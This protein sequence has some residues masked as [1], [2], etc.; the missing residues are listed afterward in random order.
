MIISCSLLDQLL[1]RN[2]WSVNNFT[3]FMLHFDIISFNQSLLF[4]LFQ[5]CFIFKVLTFSFLLL[6]FC[7]VFFRDAG[8]KVV[9]ITLFSICLSSA[10]EHDNQNSYSK[11]K[12]CNGPPS[13]N[14]GIGYSKLKHGPSH[15]SIKKV[16]NTQHEDDQDYIAKRVLVDFGVVVL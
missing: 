13:E 4:G 7:S 9:C 3:I 2:R 15:E 5:F 11:Y 6:K 12:Y 1:G 16:E 10:F 8:M 14:A